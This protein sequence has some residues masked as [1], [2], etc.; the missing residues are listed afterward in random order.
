MVIQMKNKLFK[1][2]DITFYKF[3]IVGIINTLFGTSIM[4]IFYNVFH[5]SYWIS[6]ASN[7]FFG[8]ILSYVLNRYF[9]FN[10]R[11]NSHKTIIR[12]ILNISFCYLLAYGIAKPISEALLSVFSQTVQ[13][14]VAMLIGMCLFVGLNYIGQRYFVFNEHKE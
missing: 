13:A 8:S 6:S 9:T 11:V 7:Y 12:F 1:F 14:N 4:F 3:V 2:F 5:L 10:N